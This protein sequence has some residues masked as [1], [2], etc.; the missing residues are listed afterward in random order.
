MRSSTMTGKSDE[1]KGRVKEAAGAITDND[2]PAPRRED[3]S[4]GRQSQTSRGKSRRQGEG[5]RS[6]YQYGTL[7]SQSRAKRESF[8]TSASPTEELVIERSL[9]RSDL[10]SAYTTAAVS[11]P[12]TLPCECRR[13][14]FLLVRHP[15][16]LGGANRREPLASREGSP[17]QATA[18]PRFLA[19]RGSRACSRSTTLVSSGGLSGRSARP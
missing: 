16:S 14:I 3:R 5:C 10:G 18:K 12:S 2:Q 11:R 7:A 15:G 4:S 13:P 17:S 1:A 9:C 8:R 19:I 6:P